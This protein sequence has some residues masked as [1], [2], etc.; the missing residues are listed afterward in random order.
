MAALLINA[1]LHCSA[2]NVYCVTPTVNSCSS[3]LYNSTNCTTLSEYAQE[4]E[5]Y[6]T[7]NTT[8]VFLPGD[9]TLDTNITVA[10]VARLTMRGES[11][12]DNLPTIVC[13]GP[14]GL[15]FTRMVD[16][17]VHFLS[18]TS[19]SRDFSDPSKY[20]LLLDMVELAELVNCF[21]HDNHGT[22][23]V[24]MNTNVILTGNTDFTRNYCEDD[25]CVGGG[26]IAA[27]N[28]KLTFIEDTCSSE[29]MQHLEL[30]QHMEQQ[31]ST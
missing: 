26:G 7:S 13:N 29:T 10:N 12:S 19:C 27:N 31:E 28:S 30:T 22:A 11:S 23:L 8:M 9:H 5:T 21:F 17:K 15:S 25:Y 20:A 3:C 1:V 14:V 4:A 6:F 16:L 24:V 2:E 18:F